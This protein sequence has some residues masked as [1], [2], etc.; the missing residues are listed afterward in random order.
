[1]MENISSDS[2]SSA[3]NFLEEFKGSEDLYGF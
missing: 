1:M 3:K 2:F